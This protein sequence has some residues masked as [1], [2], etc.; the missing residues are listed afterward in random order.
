MINPLIYGC[1]RSDLRQSAIEI[2]TKKF[3]CRRH[4]VNYRNGFARNALIMDW[5]LLQKINSNSDKHRD[6]RTHQRTDSRTL[7]RTAS[8]SKFSTDSKTT[9]WINYFDQMRNFQFRIKIND[10][11][12][13]IRAQGTTDGSA[14][15]ISTI[16][17]SHAEAHLCRKF[18][19]GRVFSPKSNLMKFLLSGSKFSQFVKTP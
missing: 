15:S 9:Q 16:I 18:S 8:L 5:L 10:F 7:S 17:S 13:F 11:Q 3:H 1:T 12:Y 2:F 6:P 14:S 4:H 19:S